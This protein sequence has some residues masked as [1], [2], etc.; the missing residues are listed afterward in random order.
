MSR[1]EPSLF[2]EFK[3]FPK[4][5]VGFEDQ[6]RRMHSQHADVTTTS[7]NY[8][9]YNIK[10]VSDTEYA[11]E[12]AV[13]GF[14]QDDIDIEVIA[15][16]LVIKGDSVA[17]DKDTP[18]DFLFHGIASRAFTRSFVLNDGVVVQDAQLLNG[19]LIIS[20]EKLVPEEE[21]PKKIEVRS[22]EKTLLTE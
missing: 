12:L 8:P 14:S 1:I 13:A 19:M 7:N 20:L 16:K 11:I 5:F 4:F 6:L 17:E 10:K 3:D 2:G 18:D 21:K 22:A 9:P 15:G